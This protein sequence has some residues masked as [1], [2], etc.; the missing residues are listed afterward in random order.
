ME[1][2]RELTSSF[3]HV[4]QVGHSLSW[5]NSKHDKNECDQKTFTQLLCAQ[6]SCQADPPCWVISRF[7][8]FRLFWSPGTYGYQKMESC[9]PRGCFKEVFKKRKLLNVGNR[10]VPN[11]FSHLDPRRW[12]FR[13]F[14]IL[15][16]FG[17][18]ELA[19]P[20]VPRGKQESMDFLGPRGSSGDLET[21]VSFPVCPNFL[22][23]PIFRNQTPPCRPEI[24]G[25]LAFWASLGL[26]H[27]RQTS[28]K[29]SE[30]GM[31][32][33]PGPFLGKHTK[34]CH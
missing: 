4:T 3:Q 34:A 13:I 14:G 2:G 17:P 9:S 28:G 24:M 5:T 31:E 20:S 15:G 32:Y 1:R 8:S 21:S 6:N 16:R 22:V 25:V 11:T 7:W 12:E 23:G 19:E 27:S 10:F 26:A 29:E 18:W 30:I 33:A